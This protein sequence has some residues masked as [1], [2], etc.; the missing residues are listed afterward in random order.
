MIPP[1]SIAKT[2]RPEMAMDLEEFLLGS[3][4]YKVSHYAKWPVIIVR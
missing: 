2:H 3:V 1:I 4:S